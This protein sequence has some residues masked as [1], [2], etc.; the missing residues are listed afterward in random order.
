MQ[1]KDEKAGHSC[2]LNLF[3]AKH[4]AKL[5]LDLAEE[6]TV[7]SKPLST[8]SPETKAA[9]NPLMVLR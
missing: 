6:G 8:S 3:P 2:I 9:C 1:R 7:L 5:P 4:C